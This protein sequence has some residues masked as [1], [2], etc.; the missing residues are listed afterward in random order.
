VNVERFT[1]SG[2]GFEIACARFGQGTPLLLAHPV[3][4]SKA[5]FAQAAEAWGA[6]FECVALDQ[7]GHGETEGAVE[8]EAM[9]ED[10]GRVLDH[11]GW[12]RSAMGGTS[13]GAATT[14]AFA[15]RHP[16]RVTALVQDLPGFGPGASRNPSKTE[17]MAEAFARSDFEEAARR[18][19][20]GMG[21]PRAKAWREALLNDWKHYDPARLG[22][23]IAAA[24]R[25]TAG[26]KVVERWPD[27]LSRLFMPVRILAVEGDPVHP[28]EV[29]R[30]MARAIPGARLVPRVQSLFAAAIARQWTEVL[31][32]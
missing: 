8:P 15:L 13:L 5:Y 19:T 16:E 28:M 12:E 10:V 2:P 20:E 3:V 23:K 11:L 30:T 18:A 22:P 27:D 25:A 21:A 4:F 31:E 26:W 1:V 6:R 9:V 7:R 29:A 32:S 14:L 17:G 24:L